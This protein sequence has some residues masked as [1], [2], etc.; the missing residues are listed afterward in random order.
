MAQIDYEA[1]PYSSMPFPQTQPSHLAALAALHARPA[2]PPATARVLELGCA[3]GGNL[4]PLAARFPDAVFEGVDLSARHAAEGASLIDALGLANITIR[5]GDISE[6]DL[7]GRHFDYIVCHGV[8]SWAP[9]AV[10]DAILRICGDHLAANGIAYVSYNVLPG[11]RLRLMVRDICRFHTDPVVPPQVQIAHARSMLDQTA[12]LADETTIFGKAL[13]EEALRSTQMNDTHFQGEFLG[14]H[15]APCHFHEF[16]ARAHAHGLSYLC[17]AGLPETAPESLGAERGE[18]ARKLAGSNPLAIEQYV[19]F[20]TGRLFRRSL[21]VKSPAPEGAAMTAGGLAG[22]HFSCPLTPEEGLDAGNGQTFAF[23]QDK[24]R[25]ATNDPAVGTALMQIAAAY[26]D[27]R[28]LPEMVAHVAARTRLAPAQFATRLADALLRLVRSGNVTASGLAL[29][30][31]TLDDERPALW[32]VA[33]IQLGQGQPWVSTQLHTPVQISPGVAFVSK[34]LD[35]ATPRAVIRDRMSEA[36][37]RGDLVVDG[38]AAGA[39][40]EVRQ[41]CADQL[42]GSVLRDLRRNALLAPPP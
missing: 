33:R 12:R 9:E 39:S 18:T 4:I 11:W 36:I 25:L 15:N 5:Q 14:A 34:Q 29:R 26:P 38:V 6:L 10:Q 16:M 37:R 23:Q 19:D 32:P 41:A 27:T 20:A 28:T 31:G 24:A 40:E 7:S 17:D 2:A 13:R 22:L 35:G 30:A 42:L 21:L 1:L 8:F 3:S